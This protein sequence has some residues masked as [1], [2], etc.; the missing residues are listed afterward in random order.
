MK[1]RKL[2]SGVLFITVL[3]TATPAFAI[4]NVLPTGKAKE[5]LSGKVGTSLAW[6]TGNTSL[7]QLE[8]S[9]NASYHSSAHGV[10]FKVR[11]TYGEKSDDVY[12]AKTFEHIRYRYALLNWLSAEALVQHQYDMFKKLKF[13]A[14]IGLG[15]AVSWRPFDDLSAV[16]G[17]TYLLEREVE[18]EDVA[19]TLSHF[20]EFDHR[21]SNYLQVGWQVTETIGLNSTTFLQ[22]KLNEFA[23][24]R[25]HSEN[26]LKVKANEVFAIKVSFNA[27]YVSKPYNNTQT[28]VEPLDTNLKTSLEFSF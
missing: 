20:S 23:D 9:A 15:V 24:F 21:W 10:L 2:F 3:F 11:V 26:S 6:R 7:L 17:S 19:I 14:L 28:L 27:T 18:G 1:K 16:F 25:I 8:G 22:P 13:R 12:I 5:G 4:V